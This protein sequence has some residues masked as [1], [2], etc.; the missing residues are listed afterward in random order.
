MN[1][2]EQLK[3]VGRSFHKAGDMYELDGDLTIRNVT[4]P[5]TLKV[6]YAGTVVDPYG[7]TK[8]GFTVTGKINRKDYGLT[9]DAVTEAGQV[10]V[11]ND[12][13]IQ[14]EIQLIKQQG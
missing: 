1:K 8:A 9:W 5:L 11:S 13:R 4:K 6:E 3:F 7:N 2:F 14:C 12:I 10:V